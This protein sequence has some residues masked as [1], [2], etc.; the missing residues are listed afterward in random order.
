MIVS[1]CMEI[2]CD[3]HMFSLQYAYCTTYNH[4]VIVALNKSTFCHSNT[5]YSIHQWHDKFANR[6]HELKIVCAC[7]WL[8]TIPCFAMMTTTVFNMCSWETHI[9]H[10]YNIVNCEFGHKVVGAQ[11]TNLFVTLSFVINIDANATAI[12]NNA[13]V[14]AY[15]HVFGVSCDEIQ[16]IM[17]SR[18]QHHWTNVNTHDDIQVSGFVCA[19]P[20]LAINMLILWLYVY[21]S[22]QTCENAYNICCCVCLIWDKPP[23]DIVHY[24]T[25]NV[26]SPMQMTNHQAQTPYHMLYVSTMTRDGHVAQMWYTNATRPV[27]MVCN[28]LFQC[29]AVNLKRG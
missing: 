22:I 14:I 12:P 3:E 20:Q 25:H 29:G 23:L 26:M 16:I 5:F 13:H 6:P 28:A 11:C 27:A 1:M 24:E 18:K 8:Y 10:R 21:S 4:D 2:M 15:V 9:C 19:N 17:F 7:H